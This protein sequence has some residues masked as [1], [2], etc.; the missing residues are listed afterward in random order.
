MAREKLYSLRVCAE[1]GRLPVLM[2]NSIQ[3]RIRYYIQVRVEYLRTT[4]K[5]LACEIL[6][7]AIPLSREPDSPQSASASPC[8]LLSRLF[9]GL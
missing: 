3:K 8:V 7:F 1:R 5:T 6:P 4:R 2:T 9:A